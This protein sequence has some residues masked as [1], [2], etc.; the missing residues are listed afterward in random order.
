[1]YERSQCVLNLAAPDCIRLPFPFKFAHTYFL[2]CMYIS[3]KESFTTQKGCL[4]HS[5]H[6]IISELLTT[7]NRFLMPFSQMFSLRV[8][9]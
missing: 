8:V 1:M 3:S 6:E 2:I 5:K 4:C 9:N 7:V